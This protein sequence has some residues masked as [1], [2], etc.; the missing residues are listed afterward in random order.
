MGNRKVLIANRGE[1]A[2]RIIRS[3]RTLGLATVAVFSEADR[4]AMHVRLADEAAFVGPA[5]ARESY[6]RVDAIL[7]AARRTGAHAVHPGY[8][9]LSEN[10]DFAAAVQDAGLIWVGPSPACMSAM[11]DKE[12]ARQIADQAGVP[13]LP[14]SRRFGPQDLDGLDEEARRL[15]YPLL[16]KAAAG[17][18][19]IG[20]RRVDRESDLLQAVQA[21]QSMAAKAFG[22]GSVYLE[23]YVS[24]ARHVEVQVFGYGDGNGVHLFDR[25]C[26]VQRRFQKV[27]EEAPAPGIPDRV[28]DVLYRSALALVR[29]Q[30]YSG[31]GTIEFVFDRQKERAWF[32]EMNT[33][34]QVEHPVTELITGIDLVG[35]QLE[36]AFGLLQRVS[37]ETIRASGH[38]VECR[39]YAERPEK[40]FL[41]SPGPLEELRWPEESEGLRIDT[42]VREGDRVTPYYDPMIAKLAAWGADRDAAIHRLE[43]GLVDLK[44]SGLRT[45]AEFLRQ[46]LAD[47][48]F[49]QSRVDTGLAMAVLERYVTR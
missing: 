21:T 5:P 29:A 48:D 22:D 47:D 7:D 26:S 17:G 37:Q 38:A 28:R 45:N 24:S 33:R 10:A 34:I 25:D 19:G 27:I 1:I 49:L 18:G 36:Q 40:C 31:A 41:P 32:L 46:V 20:M 4:E 15:E 44:L 43:R 3:C 42:G 14:G 9:F 23:H 13:I 2:C 35:W 11:G 8:G 6:L 12:R 30:K 39:L 16:V